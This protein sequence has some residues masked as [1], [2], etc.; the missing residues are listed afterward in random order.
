MRKID[1]FRVSKSCIK[2]KEDEYLF[3]SKNKRNNGTVDV[4]WLFED[5][6]LYSIMLTRLY[7]K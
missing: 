1:L 3:R 7:V 6:G 4:W 5:G 2:T